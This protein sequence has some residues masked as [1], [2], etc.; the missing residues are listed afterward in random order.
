MELHELGAVA[1]RDM[2]AAGEISSREL[3][4]HYLDRIAER[5]PRLGS[6]V[7]VTAER[8]LEEAAAADKAF[9]RA[10]HADHP[11]PR[12]HGLPLAWKDLLDVTGVP[13]TRG[14]AAFDLGPA[15]GDDLLVASVRA[16]GAVGLG[17]TQ[18]PEFGLTCHSENLVAPA[19]RNP[20]DPS[21][22]PGGSS[23]G[24]AAAVAA[25]L[26]PF[27]P[28]SDGGGSIRIPAAACGLVGLKPGLGAVPSDL[29]RG[30]EDNYGAPRLVVSG[31]LARTAADAALLMD[32]L[33]G[34]APGTEPHLAAARAAAPAGGRPLRIGL[35]VRSPFE[36]HLTIELE[37]EARAAL[38]AG[39]ALLERAGHRVED[40][41]L[42][43][44]NRYHPAFR[45]VWTSTLAD[46]EL[47]P[48]AE[49]RLGP[50]TRHFRARALA[51]PEGQRLGAARLLAKIA[52]DSRVQWA[53]YD[54]V[55]TP[56]LAQTPRPLGYFTAFDPEEDYERQC[57]FTPYT[58]M[59]NVAGV[60]AIA[61]PT[62]TTAAG[63]SMGV[64]LIGRRGAEAGLLALAAEIELAS[65]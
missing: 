7:T 15:K 6:F 25:G 4:R 37:P 1:L 60:P 43:Y 31:P 50:F 13:T 28:G 40:T 21:R 42:R 51:R 61:V 59:V 64:Q 46:L 26:L 48:G 2:L 62:H 30:T 33:A 47:S 38:D 17:K 24:S 55:L 63:L 54:A 34:A 32:A 22:S 56:V 65:S 58:S 8:A 39:V 9:V 45:T 5:N 49:E 12:L 11:L 57:R 14:S 23:G 10:R 52:E 19:A 53:Q 20:L 27:A 29:T 35:S 3:A 36:A 18:V 41:D 44:D 16:Q